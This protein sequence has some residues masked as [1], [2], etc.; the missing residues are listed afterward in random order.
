[1]KKL[2]FLVFVLG[3]A[4]IGFSQQLVYR[5]VNPNFGGDTFNYQQ[6]LSSANAQNSFTNPDSRAGLS[7]LDT[8]SESIN[9]QVL[10][11]LSRA[12]FGQQLGQGLQAGTYN[13]GTLSLE[14]FDSAEGVVINILDT[15][16]GEQTQIV[17]PN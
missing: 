10:G 5:P 17:V 14:I 6:L 7:D 2:L 15:T 16:T 12:I 13:L 9:R 1:M 11:Q 4:G 3:V 8:F